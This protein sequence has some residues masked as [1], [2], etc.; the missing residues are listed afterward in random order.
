MDLPSSTQG[1]N[2]N[3][4]NYCKCIVEQILVKSFISY[5]T[6]EEKQN[7]KKKLSTGGV[8]E[9]YQKNQE[10]MIYRLNKIQMYIS[11]VRS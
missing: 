10:Q 1:L 7:I 8:I 4:N 9:D 3:I 5:Q 6:F 11:I 2:L